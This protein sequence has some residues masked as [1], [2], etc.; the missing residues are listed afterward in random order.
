LPFECNLQRYIKVVP[1][2]YI[3]NLNT[4]TYLQNVKQQVRIS[5]PHHLINPGLG[6]RV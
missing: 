1:T 6:F 2:N 5:Y 4:K 3:E